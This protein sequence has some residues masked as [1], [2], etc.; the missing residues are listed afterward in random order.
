MWKRLEHV[1]NSTFLRLCSCLF[2]AAAFPKKDKRRGVLV[3][4]RQ[5][6]PAKPG[7]TL[8][9]SP[10]TGRQ[11]GPVWLGRLVELFANQTGQAWELSMLLIHTQL[12]FW[13]ASPFN[14]S[15]CLVDTPTRFHMVPPC[16]RWPRTG[17]VFRTSF[18]R[19]EGRTGAERNSIQGRLERLIPF[20]R[21]LLWLPKPLLTWAIRA[22]GTRIFTPS[23]FPLAHTEDSC[24]WSLSHQSLGQALPSGSQVLPHSRSLVESGETNQP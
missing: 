13:D 2:E 14:A 6:R 10:S 9:L 3:L 18:A 19:R 1:L 24:L 16:P 11:L 15:Q 8:R 5:R 20:C 12:G 4:F 17:P 7:R 23:C 22:F 21:V